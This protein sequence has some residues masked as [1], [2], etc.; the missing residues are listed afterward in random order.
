ML[1]ENKSGA[2]VRQVKTHASRLERIYGL[3]F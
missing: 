3:N 2:I 1:L